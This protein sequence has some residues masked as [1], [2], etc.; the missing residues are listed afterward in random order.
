MPRLPIRSYRDLVVWNKAM[1]LAVAVHRFCE[2]RRAPSFFSLTDQL[3]RA[4]NSI[5][6]NIAEGYGRRS[7]GDYRRF[8][9]IA[10]ASR[11][12]METHLLLSRRIQPGWEEQVDRILVMSEE[13]ARMLTGLHRAL[14]H[15]PSK[16]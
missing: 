9:S 14:K 11:C 4:A 1:T 13:V 7:R 16:P 2:E 10:N 15:A 8:I 12:E 5:P 3:R 6:A